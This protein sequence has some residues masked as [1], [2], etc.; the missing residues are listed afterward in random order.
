MPKEWD[1]HC[2][3]FKWELN[4]NDKVKTDTSFLS[5]SGENI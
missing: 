3:T 4:G 1:D 2:L 5:T